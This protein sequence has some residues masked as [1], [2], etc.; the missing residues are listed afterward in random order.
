MIEIKLI[1]KRLI[2]T[3]WRN[4]YS[5]RKLSI[6]LLL[7]GLLF[8]ASIIGSDVYSYQL[9]YTLYILVGIAAFGLGYMEFANI[10]KLGFGVTRKKI[11][12][13]FSINLIFMVGILIG[14]S[15]LYNLIFIIVKE[16]VN[17]LGIFNFKMLL[18]LSLLIPFFG[19]LGM[20]FANI[21]IDKRFGSI[22]FLV[23]MIIIGLE[24]FVFD[25]KLL[26]NLLLVVLIVV[27]ALVN[28]ILIYNIKMKRS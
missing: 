25:R 24:L 5:M 28:Y 27:I 26:I 20:F 8:G 3:I 11:Y 4:I 14:F 9:L 12:A 1:I 16:N 18:F 15:F 10:I 6:P 7:I 22:I 19:E 17:F 2:Y 23:I 21:K 13:H